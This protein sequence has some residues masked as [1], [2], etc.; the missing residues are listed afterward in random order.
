MDRELFTAHGLE[1]APQ[2]L[3]ARLSVQSPEGAVT[4]RITETEAY[5]GVG[6]PP[7]YDPGSHSKDRKTERN[8]SMFGPPGH[9]YVYL[10]YGVHYAINLV[11][12]PTGT[13]SAVLLRAGEIM[14]GEEL[15]VERRTAKRHQA[16]NGRSPSPINHAQLARGPGNLGTGLGIT[17]AEH[18]GL[19]LFT[20]PFH[21]E[22]P[23]QRVEHIAHGPR[24]GVAGT[25]GGTD[26]PWRF[27][28]PGDPTVSAFRPGRNAAAWRHDPVR[29]AFS[30]DTFS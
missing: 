9:A 14:E 6:T 10:S 1:V 15:A 25:A 2:L 20:A 8:A 4:L 22:L 5:H 3:G 11:C 21:L 26:F 30:W 23:S 13:A 27:W 12:S 16:A 29:D 19:D 18:D 28:I 7:P 17:R 24:V